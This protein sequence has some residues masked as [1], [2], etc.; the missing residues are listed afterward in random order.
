MFF[1]LEIM[2]KEMMQNLRFGM[3]WKQNHLK[4]CNLKWFYFDSF[5]LP[6][7][8]TQSKPQGRSVNQKR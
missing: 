3:D 5:S 7:P 2:Q 1:Y 6:E 4:R 8:E